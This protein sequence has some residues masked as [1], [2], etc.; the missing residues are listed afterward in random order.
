MR[1]HKERKFKK[2]RKKGGGRKVKKFGN[3]IKC[4]KKRV[5]TSFFF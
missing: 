4:S 1:L 5:E 3:E 2:V